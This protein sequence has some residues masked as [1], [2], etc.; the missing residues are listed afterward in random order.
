[1]KNIENLIEIK[2][3]FKVYLKCHLKEVVI[4]LNPHSNF[5]QTTWT[6]NKTDIKN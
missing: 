1:M 4:L 3:V 6:N 5:F 2:D